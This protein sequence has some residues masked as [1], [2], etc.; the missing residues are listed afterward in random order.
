MSKILSESAIQQYNRDGVYFPLP[1][2]TS[3]EAAFY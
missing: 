2:L 3:E 1:A